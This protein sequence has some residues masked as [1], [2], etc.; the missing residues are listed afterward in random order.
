[1]CGCSGA[2]RKV[3]RKEM[4]GMWQCSKEGGDVVRKATA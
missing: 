1:M 2:A 4:R 3:A